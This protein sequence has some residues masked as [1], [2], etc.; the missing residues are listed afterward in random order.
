MAP[1]L[2]RWSLFEAP[3]AHAKITFSI[4]YDLNRIHF[5]EVKIFPLVVKVSSS[6]CDVVIFLHRSLAPQNFKSHPRP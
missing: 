1:P 2:F 5:H 4:A 6:C 3:F